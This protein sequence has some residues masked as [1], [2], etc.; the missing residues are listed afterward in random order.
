MRTKEYKKEDL[1]VVWEPS[2]CIHAAICFHTLPTVFKPRE[3]PWIQLDGAERIQ[4]EDAVN[5]CP[6]GAISLKT[7]QQ[8][9][10]MS[11]ESTLPQGNKVTIINNGPAKVAGP[12]IVTM[13]DGTI[14]E[15]PNGTSICRCGLSA[16]KPFCDGSHKTNG[17]LG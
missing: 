12:C 16:T 6:T 3:R 15:K 11:S 8:E 2:L 5:A 1:I 10:D 13:P 7:Q 14:V 9:S 4:I 17:F